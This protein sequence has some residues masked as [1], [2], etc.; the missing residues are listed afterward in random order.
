MNFFSGEIEVG[1]VNVRL[2][3]KYDT[4]FINVD[5]GAE[6]EL[7][8]SLCEALDLLDGLQR[9]LARVAPNDPELE[10]YADPVRADRVRAGL[11]KLAPATAQPEAENLPEPSNPTPKNSGS[12]SVEGSGNG[13]AL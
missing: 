9:E 6:I 5:A 2:G 11:R 12:S 8:C 7:S 3:K 1:S 4:V 10:F 13:G